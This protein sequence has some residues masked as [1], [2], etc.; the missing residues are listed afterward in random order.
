MKLT[1]SLFSL[2]IVEFFLY[3]TCISFTSGNKPQEM[4][5][6]AFDEGGHDLKEK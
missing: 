1:V 2:P 6:L 4:L 5:I 3:C